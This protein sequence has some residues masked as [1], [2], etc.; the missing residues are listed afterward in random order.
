M[1]AGD[2]LLVAT[3]GVF[4]NLPVAS[5]LQLLQPVQGTC[6]LADLQKTANLIAQQAR[7]HAFDVDYMSPFALNARQNG[8]ST[9]GTVPLIAHSVSECHILSYFFDHFYFK[10]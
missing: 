3:D 2:L 1:Q 9:K 6:E 5:L 7:E 8:I 10:K 4:D